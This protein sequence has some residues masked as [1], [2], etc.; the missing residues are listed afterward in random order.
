MIGSLSITNSYFH[1]AD[2]GHEIKSR[3]EVNTIENNRIFDNYGTASYSIDLPNGGQDIVSGNMIEKGLHS[4]TNK[5]IS[6]LEAPGTGTPGAGSDNGHW[7][8]SSLDVSDNT[9]VNDK[10]SSGVIAL[11]NADTI[12]V[13]PTGTG[14]SFWNIAPATAV[15]GPADISGD[16]WLTGRPTLSTAHPWIV[17]PLS[18]GMSDRLGSSGRLSSVLLRRISCSMFNRMAAD[19]ALSLFLQKNDCTELISLLPMLYRTGKGWC[20]ASHDD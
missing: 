2:A 12:P 10:T 5:M 20:P 1:D 11:W 18:A 6:F 9:F 3:A 17:N 14:N 4:E 16:T 19:R 13:T 8:N 7:A 15:L